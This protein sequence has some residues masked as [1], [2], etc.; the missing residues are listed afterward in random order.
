MSLFNLNNEN[1][2]QNLKKTGHS[3]IIVTAGTGAYRVNT[4]IINPTKSRVLIGGT[5]I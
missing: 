3:L 5:P 4:E 2:D 1:I